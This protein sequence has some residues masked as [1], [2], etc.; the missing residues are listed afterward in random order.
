MIVELASK[1]DLDKTMLIQI[2]A[3]AWVKEGKLYKRILFTDNGKK[4]VVIQQIDNHRILCS[5]SE[6]KSYFAFP[7]CSID[8][9][10]TVLR[11]LLEY[12]NSI[13]YMKTDPFEAI[14]ITI[15]SQGRTG[16]ATRKAFYTLCK[17][18]PV[19]SPEAIIKIGENKL[20]DLIK[21]AGPYK[22]KYITEMCKYIIENCIDLAKLERY[23]SLRI[24]KILSRLPGIGIKTAA[25]VAVYAYLRDDVFPID[26]HFFRVS[27]RIGLL[28]IRRI[29]STL[30]EYIHILN[31]SKKLGN[32][33]Y[34]HILLVM[35]GKEICNSR[36][37]KCNI[38]PVK[39]YCRWYYENRCR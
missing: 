30:E 39:E 16:E 38:C 9:K 27:N 26:T 11:K 34:A 24:I 32:L 23:S 10:S 12:Y 37:P 22:A 18:I 31:A 19:L 36:N 20:R 21:S 15:L 8:V 13:Y 17:N 35:L 33:G 6:I 25:C 29:P 3:L 2:P 28:N 5:D 4:E 14:L 7:L 1:I